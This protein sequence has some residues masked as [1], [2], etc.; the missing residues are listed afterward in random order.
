MQS[1]TL[2]HY[3][4]YTESELHPLLARL[5]HLVLHAGTGKLVAIK[6]KYQSSKFMRI[7]KCAELNSS[8]VHELAAQVPGQAWSGRSTSDTAGPR[9][10]T[11]VWLLNAGLTMYVRPAIGFLGTRF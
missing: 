5:A 10:I 9:D 2:V 7:S 1:P 11:W 8:V 6:T 4:R 3:S